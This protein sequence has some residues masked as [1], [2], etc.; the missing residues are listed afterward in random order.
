MN[1]AFTDT[2]RLLLREVAVMLSLPQIC[3]Q[4][5]RVLDNPDHSRKDVAN[6]MR[7]DPALTARLLRIVNSPYFG[8]PYRVS[9]I[10]QALGILGEQELQNLVLVTSLM[11]LSKS[12]DTRMDITRFW[13]GSVYT[14][15]LARNLGP[16]ELPGTREELFVTG[17]LLNVGKLPLYCKEPSLVTAVEHEMNSRGCTEIAAERLL[18]GTD[19]CS[20]GAVLAESWN[21][22]VPMQE[23]IG[24]HHDATATTSGTALHVLRLAGYF[25]DWHERHAGQQLSPDCQELLDCPWPL[26]P[27]GIDAPYFWQQLQNSHTEHTEVFDLFCGDL[28]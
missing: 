16:P 18:T 6:V 13:R 25:G 12:I 4:L 10:S 28:H 8:L 24:A 17:L 15:V 22:P 19:H 7:F 23:H 20:I 2:A 14:A 9:S 21:F 1:T 5:R 27:L 11:S 26:A 3:M